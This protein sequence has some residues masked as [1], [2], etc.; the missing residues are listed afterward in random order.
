MTTNNQ[1]LQPAGFLSEVLNKC[2][3]VTLVTYVLSGMIKRFTKNDDLYWLPFYMFLINFIILAVMTYRITTKKISASRKEI[4]NLIFQ[5]IV[6]L[7]GLM[8][9]YYADLAS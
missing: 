4:R 5:M 2:S 1:P 3:F 6:N 8:A 7:I 9:T